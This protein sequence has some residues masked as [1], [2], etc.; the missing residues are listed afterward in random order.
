MGIAR[1]KIILDIAFSCSTVPSD[2]VPDIVSSC[3]AV[4]RFPS[5]CFGYRGIALSCSLRPHRGPSWELSWEPWSEPLGLCST[6]IGLSWDFPGGPEGLLKSS[7]RNLRRARPQ[8]YS[9][10][11]GVTGLFGAA[12]GVSWAV[13]K[14]HWAQLGAS[15]GGAEGIS[16]ASN[17]AYNGRALKKIIFFWVVLLG[18]RIGRLL[19]RL[20]SLFGSLGS[21]PEGLLGRFRGQLGSLGG[22]LGGRR[23]HLKSFQRSSQW[24]RP[25]KYYIFLGGPSWASSWAPLGPSWERISLSGEPAWEAP[26]PSSR[27][28][29]LSWAFP[30]GGRQGHLKSFE[31]GL[32]WARP[33]K[34]YI[35]LGGVLRSRLGGLWGCLGGLL[36]SLGALLGRPQGLLTSSERTP[37]KG[38]P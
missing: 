31:R 9:I 3:I 30:G 2:P 22:L 14:A 12:L 1:S 7:Q 8:T 25:E 35:F 29:R 27:L 28:V 6:C 21:R 18:H 10:T 34:Y 4:P 33:E 32:R 5:P 15:W 17:G 13:L 20:R 38:A 19:G 23:G 36:R 37:T 26:G 11:L 24:A 16:E